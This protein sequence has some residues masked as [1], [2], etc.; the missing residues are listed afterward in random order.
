MEATTTPRHVTTHV[1]DEIHRGAGFRSLKITTAPDA[2]LDPFVSF[3]HFHMV[4]PTFEPHPHAGLSAVTYLFERSEGSLLSRESSGVVCRIA[5]GAVRW[6]EAGRGIVHE[7]SPLE[8]GRDCHGVQ[9]LVNLAAAD[10]LGAPRALHLEPQQIPAPALHPRARVRVLCGEAGGVR[11]PLEPRSPVTL[12]DVSLAPGVSFMT[13][14]AA[15]HTA[16]VVALR[17]DGEVGLP[18]YA[19]P[20]GPDTAAAF[21][22]GRGN[23]VAR[24]GEAGLHVLIAGGRPFGEPVV[25]EGPFVMTS[26]EEIAAAWARHA[27]GEMGR[28]SSS[29]A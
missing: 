18:G 5:P 12:L 27:A 24:A 15:D 28:L 2:P 19:V 22:T 9:I 6:M 21:S 3:E 23:V 14:L 20:L 7:E 29:S 11:S 10:K 25:F 8:R 17:G 4:E 1:L 13:V 26:R 16:F